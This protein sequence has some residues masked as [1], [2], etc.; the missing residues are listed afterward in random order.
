MT[1][2][3]AVTDDIL[4]KFSRCTHELQQCIL[5]G[6]LDPNFVL[7]SLKKIIEGQSACLSIETWPMTFS[8]RSYT[9]DVDRKRSPAI[10]ANTSGVFRKVDELAGFDPPKRGKKTVK[11]SLVQ[12]HQSCKISVL[13][14]YIAGAGYDVA[15]LYETLAFARAADILQIRGREMFIYCVGTIDTSQSWERC[16]CL[17]STSLA[18]YEAGWYLNIFSERIEVNSDNRYVLVKKKTA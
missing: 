8:A 5:E 14:R 16:V 12:I 11:L 6:T 1:T 18:A 2:K 13:K 9:V 3:L 10:Q 4:G 7:Q 15:D 17:R